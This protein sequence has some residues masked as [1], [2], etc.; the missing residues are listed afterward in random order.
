MADRLVTIA[1]FYQAGEARL[2]QN[3]LTAAGIKAAVAD[4]TVIQM[5]WL[6][7]NAVGG[8]KVQVREA[9]AERAVAEL[10]RS[11]G[12]DGEGFGPADEAALAAEAEAADREDDDPTEPE[13][14]GPEAEADPLPVTGSRD[15]YARRLVLT[16]VFGVVIPPIWFYALYLLLN[17]AFGPGLLS[18]RGR[19]DLIVGGLILVPGLVISVLA[20]SVFLRVL[21]GLG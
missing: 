14:A 11:F 4:E 1:T 10:E 9:D 3:A 7:A 21:L 5:D 12:A 17:A 15:E 16:G 6:L 19:F 8:I 2:A 13:E 18:A 20:V